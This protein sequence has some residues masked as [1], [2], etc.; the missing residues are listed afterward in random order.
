MST[1]FGVWVA[2]ICTL[3]MFSFLWKENKLFRSF[4]HIYVGIAAGYG[5]V[6]QYKAINNMAVTPLLT[7]GAT[8]W[9]VPIIMG[10]LLFTRFFKGIAWMSRW[11]LAFLIGIGAALAIKILET[12]FIRQAQASI[13]PLNSFNNWV[14]VLGTACGVFYFFFTIKPMPGM[15]QLAKIGRYVLMISFGA[16]FGNAVMGRVSLLIS[17]MQFLFGDWIKL[18]KM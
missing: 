4:Q 5:M 12:E 7:K 15:N 16:G 14:L 9:I 1:D 3:A 6:Q 17:R 10:L 13:V 2:A 8:T 11:S 18:I